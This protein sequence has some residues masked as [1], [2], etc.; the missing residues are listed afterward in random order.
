MPL[1]QTCWRF[2]HPRALTQGDGHP[3]PA[4]AG[5]PIG[6]HRYLEVLSASQVLDNLR[7]INAPHV[8]AVQE[9]KSGAHD[10]QVQRT[11]SESLGSKPERGFQIAEKLISKID[12]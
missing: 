10:W 11:E 8:D 1:V 12:L 5:S 4:L 3:W 7:A 6:C 9:V 2:N